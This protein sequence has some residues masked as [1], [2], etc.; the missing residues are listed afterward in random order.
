M[1]DV[2]KS[3]ADPRISRFLQFLQTLHKK[4]RKNRQ[5]LDQINS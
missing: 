2:T 5:I 4:F 3:Q 1:S